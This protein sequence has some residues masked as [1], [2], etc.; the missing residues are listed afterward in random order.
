MVRSKK[1]EAMSAGEIQP[2]LLSALHCCGQWRRWHLM[3]GRL[4]YYSPT[5]AS[6]LKS[7]EFP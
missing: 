1:I 4:H 3:S 7:S 2:L 6:E 5:R